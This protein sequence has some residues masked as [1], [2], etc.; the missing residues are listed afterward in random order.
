MIIKYDD[1]FVQTRSKFVWHYRQVQHSLGLNAILEHFN[2]HDFTPL[3]LVIWQAWRQLMN[4]FVICRLQNLRESFKQNERDSISNLFLEEVCVL[5]TYFKM[6]M[7]WSSLKYDCLKFIQIDKLKQQIILEDEKAA[8][9]AQEKKMVK[10]NENGT[11]SS[12][13]WNEDE[14]ELLIKAVKLFPAGTNSR[15]S[16]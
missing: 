14:Q 11:S 13:L 1:Q 10:E 4:I 6:S 15:C 5:E 16:K 2:C 12:S 7:L 8:R 3:T 9:T